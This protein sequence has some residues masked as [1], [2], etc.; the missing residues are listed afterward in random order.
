[1]SRK[2]LVWC[3]LVVVIALPALVFA[4]VGT[5]HR[6][7]GILHLLLTSF[8]LGAVEGL[9]VNKVYH[10][11]KKVIIPIMISA[12]YF[13]M[14]IGVLGMENLRAY[15]RIS[16]FL[17]MVI[18]TLL[19]KDQSEIVKNYTTCAAILIGGIWGYITFIRNR[20]KYPRANIKH[21]IKHR[22]IDDRRV[23]LRITI[24]VENKGDVI[25]SL[26]KGEV[27][28]QQMV[29]WPSDSA[30]DAIDSSKET[31][32]NRKAEA[33]WPVL[34]DRNL[35]GVKGHEIEPG[36]F[37]EFHYDFVIDSNI[38]TVIVYSYVKNQ[39]KLGRE[40]GWNKTSVYDVKV[41]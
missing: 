32:K 25:I 1:M 28:I 33:E 36:E 7:A 41:D 5:P 16:K 40:I 20:Q 23:L 6:L 31:D 13:S 19:N 34:A 29:P 38:K 9:L 10:V 17:V 2:L 14:W 12:N 15:D 26:D 18:S 37:D 39:T 21:M 35:S 27:W 30:L 24:A 8:L 4:S 22:H 11:P 3:I